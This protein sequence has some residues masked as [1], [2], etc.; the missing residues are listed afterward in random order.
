VKDRVD[1]Q[2]RALAERMWLELEGKG[3]VPRVGG[4][5]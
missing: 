3:I 4:K 5:R 1:R 2:L